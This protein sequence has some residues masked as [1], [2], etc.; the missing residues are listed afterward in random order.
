MGKHS[1]RHLLAV[2]YLAVLFGIVVL[3]ACGAQPTSP[4]PAQS[5]G[6][7]AAALP[8]GDATRGKEVFETNG[9]TACHTTTDEKLVGPGLRGVLAGQGEYG[10]NLPNGKPITEENVA[11]WIRTGGTGKVGNMPSYPD[12]TPEQI[13]DLI[14]YLKTLQ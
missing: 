1:T 12:L 8:V 3:S 6:G 9:C 14:A 10:S 11:G 2:V 4:A 13:G 7:A 5:S